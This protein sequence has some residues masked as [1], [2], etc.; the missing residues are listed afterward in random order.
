MQ[1]TTSR[2]FNPEQADRITVDEIIKEE[3]AGKQFTFIDVRNPQAWAESDSKIKGALRIPLD[4]AEKR[5][6]EIPK[7][8]TVITYCT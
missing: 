6:G 7:D 1:Q 2:S 5:I 8:R 3:K 4:E